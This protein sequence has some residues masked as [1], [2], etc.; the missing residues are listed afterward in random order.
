MQRNVLHMKRM[1]IFLYNTYPK[2]V[3]SDKRI[4]PDL[5]V[6]NDSLSLFLK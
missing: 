3:R 5:I 1:V 2:K 4:V 6:I